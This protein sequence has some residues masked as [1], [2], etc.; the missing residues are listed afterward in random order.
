V[1]L[2]ATLDD[3]ISLFKNTMLAKGKR[4][5]N[6][7]VASSYVVPARLLYGQSWWMVISFW[8]SPCLD[9]CAKNKLGL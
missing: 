1:Q 7:H 4:V 5:E 8:I 9:E 6:S 2:V 3:I